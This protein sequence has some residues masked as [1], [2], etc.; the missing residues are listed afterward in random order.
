MR[1]EVDEFSEY[2]G[3]EE[4]PTSSARVPLPLAHDLSATAPFEG[5]P[6]AIVF[7]ETVPASSAGSRFRFFGGGAMPDELLADNP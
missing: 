2:F 6:F 4:T 3:D 1:E 7:L 5:R